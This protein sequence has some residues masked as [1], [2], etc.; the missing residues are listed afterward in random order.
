MTVGVRRKGCTP[1]DVSVRPFPEGS[2]SRSTALALRLARGLTA[3]LSEDF[4]LL[5]RCPA[6]CVTKADLRR[7]WTWRFCLTSWETY[8]TTSWHEWSPSGRPY[9]NSNAMRENWLCQKFYRNGSW[10]K[11][12]RMQCSATALFWL[13]ELLLQVIED[14]Q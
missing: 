1:E 14:Q 12:W 5:A 8:M 10:H 2:V 9:I 6:K 3:C 4:R 11:T 13:R 7:H